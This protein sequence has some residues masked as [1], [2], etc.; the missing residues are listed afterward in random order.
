MNNRKLPHTPHAGLRREYISA[1]AS[2]PYSALAW[3]REWDPAGYDV[4]SCA[5][6]AEGRVTL[7]LCRPLPFVKRG[8]TWEYRFRIAS[9]LEDAHWLVWDGTGDW[10]TVSF[11]HGPNETI[12]VLERHPVVGPRLPGE[13]IP[14]EVFPDVCDPRAHGLEAEP[15]IG[16]IHRERFGGN[17]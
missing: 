14:V 10:E 2:C 12:A 17:H 6:D 13:V 8:S 16:Q 4:V 9:C 1:V 11:S 7:L 5:Q 15:L 3:I